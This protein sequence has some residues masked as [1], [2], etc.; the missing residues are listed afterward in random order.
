M[1]DPGPASNST[2]M[3]ATVSALGAISATF[4]A[5]LQNTEHASS[6]LLPGVGPSGSGSGVRTVVEGALQG[7][8]NQTARVRDQ[9]QSKQTSQLEEGNTL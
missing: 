3:V 9:W 6:R 4:N 1:A 5:S 8:K 7:V 2:E